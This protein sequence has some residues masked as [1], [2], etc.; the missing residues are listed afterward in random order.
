MGNQEL[1]LK[2]DDLGY[3]INARD[4][5]ERIQLLEYDFNSLEYLQTLL[6]NI[7]N[8]NYGNKEQLEEVISQ[9]ISEF[10]NIKNGN[11]NE[12]PLAEKQALLEQINA[13]NKAMDPNASEINIQNILREDNLSNKYSNYIELINPDGTVERLDCK[14]P[15]AFAK[16]FSDHINDISSWNAQEIFNF[17]KKYMEDKLEVV[18]MAEMFTN[19]ELLEHAVLQ[20]DQLIDNQRKAVVEY[21]LKV[22]HTDLD[23]IG[24]MV[25]DN[26]D[27]RW[28]TDGKDMLMFVDRGEYEELVLVTPGTIHQQIST[29]EQEAAQNSINNTDH[30][31][32]TALGGSEKHEVVG[33][34]EKGNLS[35]EKDAEISTDDNIEFNP[36]RFDELL[37][38]REIY[39]QEF[40]MMITEKTELYSM[41]ASLIKEFKTKLE[42]GQMDAT[43]LNYLD[44]FMKPILKIVQE[45]GEYNLD[46]NDIAYYREYIS[47]MEMV[48]NIKSNQ[49]VEEQQN[50]FEG[51]QQ[52]LL[53]QPKQLRMLGPG[54]KGYNQK[55]LNR[56]RGVASIIILFE[57]ALV[58]GIILSIITLVLE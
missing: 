11:N 21:A 53:Q 31:H 56:P 2:I 16:F 28:T 18:P 4:L 6:Q 48:N 34:I 26:G 45:S 17:F 1:N 41:L 32:T 5:I 50:T 10:E 23:K 43:L 52:H 20:D 19:H 14:N 57:V 13:R 35:K 42:K 12:N 15:Q 27:L 47:I 58:A 7:S 46:A 36:Q 39:D 9:K 25:D 54:Q 49:R 44:A 3:I 22:Q 40:E 24:V 38:L 8:N 29:P 55:M 30:D 37:N 51:P 33:R